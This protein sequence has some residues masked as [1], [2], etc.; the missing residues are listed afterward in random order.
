MVAAALV[1]GDLS[2]GPYFRNMAYFVLDT[3]DEE[4][5]CGFLPGNIYT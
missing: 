3:Y 5:H 2:A 4:Y 1:G